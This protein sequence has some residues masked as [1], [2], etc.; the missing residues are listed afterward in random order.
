[1][2][3]LPLVIVLS[4]FYQFNLTAPAAAAA[5]GRVGAFFNEWFSA[6]GREIE[7]DERFIT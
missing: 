3:D 4:L 1:M 2:L 6:Q 5:A 7:R